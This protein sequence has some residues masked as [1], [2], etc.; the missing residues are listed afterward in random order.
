MEHLQW[1]SP[2]KQTKLTQWSIFIFLQNPHSSSCE[3]LEWDLLE[4]NKIATFYPSCFKHSFHNATWHLLHIKHLIYFLSWNT[5]ITAWALLRCRISIIECNVK[6]KL[7]RHWLGTEKLHLTTRGGL[8]GNTASIGEINSPANDTCRK[9]R[10]HLS[11]MLRES[12]S[13]QI[14]SSLG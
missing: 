8:W 3:Q 4:N 5:G 10:I 12:R 1:K 7:L 11:L 9:P 6:T 14:I 2:E 13:G